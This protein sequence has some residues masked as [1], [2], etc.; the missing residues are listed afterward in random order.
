[1]AGLEWTTIAAYVTRAIAYLRGRSHRQIE[2]RTS[3]AK[4]ELAEAEAAL[5]RVRVE[6]AQIEAENA[7][8]MASSATINSLSELLSGLADQLEAASAVQRQ[9]RQQIRELER[10]LEATRLELE[11]T[12][13]ELARTSQSRLRAYNLE[14]PSI[15]RPTVPPDEALTPT[16]MNAPPR[17]VGSS[18]AGFGE[19]A[20][21]LTGLPSQPGGSGSAK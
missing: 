3:T 5:S 19:G 13:A 15:Y 9:Q 7:R 1:M 2:A 11:A 16:P 12:R 18:P 4:A 17:A 8:V 10:A 6:A 21:D 20:T 14:P